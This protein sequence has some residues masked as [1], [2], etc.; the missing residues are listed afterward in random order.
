MAIFVVQAGNGEGALERARFV[1]EG[2]S[3]PAFAFAPLWL[4]FGRLWLALLLYLAAE[5]AFLVVVFPHVSI[6]AALAVDLAA[7]VWLGTEA[8][9]LRLAKGERRAA[10]V[11][12]VEAR[13]RDE[14]ETA[15]FRGHAGL[16]PAAGDVPP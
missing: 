8:S 16:P 14:A 9:R 10:L 2:F 12:I 5:V 13:D 6:A 15:F 3:W 4:L 1:R 11:A 7:R